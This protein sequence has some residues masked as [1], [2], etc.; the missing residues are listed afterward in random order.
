MRVSERVKKHR[1][2]KPQKELALDENHSFNVPSCNLVSYATK[3]IIPTESDHN[4]SLFGRLL[5]K[6]LIEERQIHEK[7]QPKAK[8]KRKKSKKKSTNVEES[9]IAD[10]PETVEPPTPAPSPLKFEDISTLDMSTID[11]QDSPVV[12]Q[13]LN[14][15]AITQHTVPPLKRNFS[16][17]CQR[18]GD[19]PEKVCISVQEISRELSLSSCIKCRAAAE[20]YW[21]STGIPVHDLDIVPG[22]HFARQ[23]IIESGMIDR[24]F[25]KPCSQF[26]VWDDIEIERAF[27]YQSMEEGLV[28]CHT[29]NLSTQNDHIT[30]EIVVLDPVVESDGKISSMQVTTELDASVISRLVR[31]IILPCGLAQLDNEDMPPISDNQIELIVEQ[32]KN[33]EGLFRTRLNHLVERKDK[34]QSAFHATA[35]IA[36]HAVGYDVKT[37]STLTDCDKECDQ[38]LNVIASL[39]MDLTT[40]VDGIPDARWAHL[41]TKRLWT[42]FE[43]GAQKILTKTLLHEGKLLQLANRPGVVPQ[44]F[45]NAAHRSSVYDLVKEKF[46]VIEALCLALDATIQDEVEINGGL[47]FLQNV[48]LHQAVFDGVILKSQN[49]FKRNSVDDKLSRVIVGFVDLFHTV[50][51]AH[52]AEIQKA[53]ET[54]CAS[55]FATILDFKSTLDLEFEALCKHT[56][57]QHKVTDVWNEMA[58]ITSRYEEFLPRP[59]FGEKLEFKLDFDAQ[60]THELAEMRK[61]LMLLVTNVVSR[62]RYLRWMR[63][64]TL[65]AKVIPSQILK[66][67]Y[68]DEGNRTFMCGGGRRRVACVLASLIYQ[69]LV[70]RCNE[71]HAEVT[72]SELLLLMDKPENSLEST[73]TSSKKQS[74][75]KNTARF[76]TEG[77]SNPKEELIPS[78]GS[79]TLSSN[80]HDV[81]QQAENPVVLLSDEQANVQTIKEENCFESDG[82][83]KSLS[84]TETEQRIFTVPVDQHIDPESRISVNQGVEECL[85]PTNGK[86]DTAMINQIPESISQVCSNEQSRKNAEI[87]KHTTNLMPHSSTTSKNQESMSNKLIVSN[88]DSN[89]VS[90]M[91]QNLS[92]E[93]SISTNDECLE[94]VTSNGTSNDANIDS[95]NL[96]EEINRIQFSPSHLKDTE[97]LSSGCEEFQNGWKCNPN[98]TSPRVT[99]LDDK[100]SITQLNE[101]Y[102]AG[103][104]TAQAISEEYKQEIDCEKTNNVKSTFKESEKLQYLSGTMQLSMMITDELGNKQSIEEFLVSRL[105]VVLQSGQEEANGNAITV[106]E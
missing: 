20:S 99:L 31:Q 96:A 89:D 57:G 87:M 97:K 5:L 9:E 106:L 74:K 1:R 76:A 25:M 53:H 54:K 81:K 6:H 22:D 49:W 32:V 82:E 61:T 16:L 60:V 38:I 79:K 13:W 72:E 88:E 47:P 12:L 28:S 94:V 33:H 100:K 80:H 67:L 93:V 48:L 73:K 95:N 103:D 14:H 17:F 84:V 90:D 40:L 91:H 46:Q 35:M 104:C 3:D 2:K 18:I 41:R 51:S 83:F 55:L 75:R 39:I 27:D 58:K 86:S 42:S 68:Q 30:D 37:A 29:K 66:Q 15:L 4:P 43:V 98:E 62:W 50:R 26:L 70:S 69:Q 85:D 7:F 10:T 101:Q 19:S 52:L 45:L 92:K 63:C 78:E 34:V 36:S 64:R 77:L 65:E 71:W 44:M 11:H 21:Q 56:S 23:V 105:L 24:T 59:I 8:K 102:Q